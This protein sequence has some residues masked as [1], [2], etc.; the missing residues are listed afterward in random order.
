MI[1]A[2]LCDEE[3]LSAD[4]PGLI[5]R[6]AGLSKLD[7]P[8]VGDVRQFDGIAKAS[9][10]VLPSAATRSTSC[11]GSVS[12][13]FAGFTEQNAI[14][15]RSLRAIRPSGNAAFKA[16]PNIRYSYPAW[17]AKPPLFA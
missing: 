13:L 2:A 11:P 17:T 10:L 16:A 4:K 12:I 1:E 3:N 5:R 8:D 6:K 7:F 14:A 15:W 9:T